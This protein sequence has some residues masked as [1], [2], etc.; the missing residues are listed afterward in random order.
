MSVCS[1]FCFSFYLSGLILYFSHLLSF[2]LLPTIMT[3]LRGETA[4]IGLFYEFYSSYLPTSFYAPPLSYSSDGILPRE[5]STDQ[6]LASRLVVVLLTISC[7]YV[8]NIYR[9]LHDISTADKYQTTLIIILLRKLLSY[10]NLLAFHRVLN[11]ICAAFQFDRKI[12]AAN[13]A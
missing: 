12:A 2:L 9:Q 8:I 6:K 5:W 13:Q 4:Q 10:T 11:S 7:K 3:Y 1:S